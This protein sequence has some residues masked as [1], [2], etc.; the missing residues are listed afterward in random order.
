MSTQISE[1]NN[2]TGDER[3][4]ISSFVGGGVRG[5][6]L[7]LTLTDENG[8]TQLTEDKVQTLFQALAVW[9]GRTKCDRTLARLIAVHDAI[10]KARLVLNGDSNDAEHDALRDLVEALDG[11]TIDEALER[12]Y[13][14]VRATTTSSCNCGDRF[15]PRCPIHGS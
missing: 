2:I 3:L 1:I 11:D 12:S 4:Y 5:Q 10:Q 15:S 6:C 14:R 9:L 13:N 7:Q 8:Y